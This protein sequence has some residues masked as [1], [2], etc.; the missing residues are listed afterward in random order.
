MG[1]RATVAYENENGTWT[2]IQ[3]LH[4]GYLEKGLGEILYRCYNSKSAAH[5]L[6]D[7]GYLSSVDFL[8]T[9]CVPVQDEEP[10]HI[11]KDDLEVFNSYL[12]SEYFYFY[13]AATC[14]WYYGKH[15]H[16]MHKLEFKN[17]RLEKTVTLN[18]DE[19]EVIENCLFRRQIHLEES[20]LTDAKCY[21]LIIG[22]RNKLK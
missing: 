14:S 19:I 2:A 21:K 13:D 20:N 7:L 22:I 12:D 9:N 5:N 3:V 17:N 1:T 11:F 6:V 10:A 16:E 4:D 18:K 15:D 8:L